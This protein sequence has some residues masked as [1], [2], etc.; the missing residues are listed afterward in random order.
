MKKHEGL[1][2]REAVDPFKEEAC[3]MHQTLEIW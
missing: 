2:G 3:S 1:G